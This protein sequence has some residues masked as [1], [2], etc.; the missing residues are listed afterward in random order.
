MNGEE[1]EN[2]GDEAADRKTGPT[3]QELLNIT[4][5]G[6]CRY[7]IGTQRAFPA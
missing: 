5:V 1:P 7:R 3:G 2:S 6:Y 4:L